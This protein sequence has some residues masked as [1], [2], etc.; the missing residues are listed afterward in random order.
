MKLVD[1]QSQQG[2]TDSYLACCDYVEEHQPE[3]KDIIPAMMGIIFEICQAAGL[4]SNY[5][6]IDTPLNPVEPGLPSDEDD[7][8]DDDDDS[9]GQGGSNSSDSSYKPDHSPLSSPNVSGKRPQKGNSN[10]ATKGNKRPKRTTNNTVLVNST[11]RTC[12]CSDI[13]TDHNSLLS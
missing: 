13:I 5:P 8:E 12:F 6:M 4:I 7:D 2:I 3:S 9:Q 11:H 10:S 1:G